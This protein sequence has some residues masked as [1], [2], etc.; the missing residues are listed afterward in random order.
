[1]YFLYWPISIS[2]DSGVCYGQLRGREDGNGWIILS[3]FALDSLPANFLA[4]IH[5]L[6]QAFTLTCS[7]RSTLLSYIGLTNIAI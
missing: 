1:M 4:I 6:A 7:Y 3:A 2:Q 5:I